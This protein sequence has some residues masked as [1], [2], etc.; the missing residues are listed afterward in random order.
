MAVV[1]EFTTGP[2]TLLDVGTLSY[3]GC[4]FSPLFASTLSGSAIKD[5][6]NRTVKLVEYS[7]EVDG[8]VTASDNAEV[9]GISPTMNNLAIMLTAQG[10]AL[11]YEG[12]GFDLVVNAPGAARFDKR[13]R[14]VA[15]GPTPELLDFQ[16]LGGGRAAKVKWRVKV[17]LVE[18]TSNVAVGKDVGAA[19]PLLQ[20][21]CE[22]TV[23]YGEDGYSTLSVRGTMEIPLGRSTQ[24]TRTLQATVD[25]ARSQLDAR[26]FGGID[27]SR[28]RVLSRDYPVSRDKRTMEFNV[29]VEEKPYMDLPPGCTIARGTFSVRP[30]KAGMGL[31]QWHCTL[32]ATYTVRADQPRRLAWNAF[33]T[34]LRL[35]MAWSAAGNV[36][37]PAGNQNPNNAG[38]NIV[39]A[40]NP[41]VPIVKAGEKLGELWN[42][43]VKANP[44]IRPVLNKAFLIDFSFD[45]GLYLDSKTTSF[46]ATWRMITTFSHVLVA[47]GLWRKVPE[48]DAQGNNLWATT[49]AD[50]S[51]S[52]SWL[53][54]A[55]D[56]ATDIIVDFG[57]G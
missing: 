49:M 5:N 42:K 4:T 27:L 45:E 13:A 15:W 31:C 23:S 57:G 38:R 46:S 37:Q 29:T 11:V 44:G 53:P 50:I 10:G 19:T 22:T 6:A 34:L 1:H 35:R 25:N 51:G 16:P 30:A 56:P 20:F 17:H 9:N 39:R 52:R 47:S 2:A 26:I 7:L 41:F 21:N 36:P 55:L 40:G 12:R 32:R 54:N 18:Y 3:N 8:Y 14:D 28:F 33:L 24:G 48:E 43:Q